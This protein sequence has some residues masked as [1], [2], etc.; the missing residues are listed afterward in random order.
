ML[1]AC[2]DLRASDGGG[3]TTEEAVHKAA[4]CVWMPGGT[5]SQH[6]AD[7]CRWTDEERRLVLISCWCVWMTEWAS[8]TAVD[9]LMIIKMEICKA[10][11]LWL[12]ALNKHSITHI[13][14][15][16][17]ENV[18]SNKKKKKKKLSMNHWMMELCI[19]GLFVCFLMLWLAYFGMC[20]CVCM[21]VCVCVCVCPTDSSKR[22]LCC[23]LCCKVILCSWKAHF[24]VIHRQ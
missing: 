15:I 19:Y 20:V 22:K 11:T 9:F 16:E 10:P 23:V 5:L 1:T 21:Y 3:G 17:M 2:V 12:K 18:I 24:C 13:K 6:R 4:G 14:Y 8:V 7:C